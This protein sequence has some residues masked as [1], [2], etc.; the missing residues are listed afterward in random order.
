[1]TR[2]LNGN[3]MRITQANGVVTDYVFDALDR[4]TS[5]STHPDAHT[6]LTTGYVL[7]SNGQPTSRTTGDNVTVSYG[8]DA[9]SRLST[10]PGSLRLRNQGPPMTS[11]SILKPAT[12]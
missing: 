11:I 3:A 12:L 10:V 2:D 7:D 1:M 9:L 8:Y 6:T 4:L 5:V